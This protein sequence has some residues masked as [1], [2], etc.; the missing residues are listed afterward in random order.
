MRTVEQNGWR[1]LLR[2]VFLLRNTADRVKLLHGPYETPQ[3]RRGDWAFG[4]FRDCDFIMTSWTDARLPWPRCLPIDMQ[5]AA[6]PRLERK[7]LHLAGQ[8][9]SSSGTPFSAGIPVR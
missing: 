4:L 5:D 6:S 1:V 9:V 8:E 3:L 7:S 2:R